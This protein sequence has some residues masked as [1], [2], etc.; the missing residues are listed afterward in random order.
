ML[1][2]LR[3]FF[4]GII[5]VG[6]ILACTDHLPPL[7]PLAPASARL[8]LKST[9]NS[10]S[11]SLPF[12]T[13]YTYGSN[14]RVS[15]FTTTLG[16]KAV[17]SYDDQNRYSRFNYYYKLTDESNGETTRF[18]YNSGD[19]GFSQNTD[20]IKNGVNNGNLLPVVYKLDGNSRLVSKTTSSSPANASET[21]T[22]TGDNITTVVSVSGPSTTTTKYEYDDKPNPYY[23]LI[24]PDIGDIRRFSRNNT[25]KIINGAVSTEYVYEYNAQGLSTKISAKDGT[26][27]TRLTYESY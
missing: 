21:Y 10:N 4:L 24:A 22:Y 25:T 19:A 16:S 7:P 2:N 11:T 6:S 14:N 23:G 12:S 27:L 18:I 13:E 15:S 5:L 26:V 17:F 8:R 3:I 20:F 1:V 9:N